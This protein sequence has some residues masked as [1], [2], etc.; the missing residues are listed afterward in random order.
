MPDTHEKCSGH[1]GPQENQAH[2]DCQAT[3]GADI[4]DCCQLFKYLKDGGIW[5]QNASN[6]F[7]GPLLALLPRFQPLFVAYLAEL[8]ALSTWP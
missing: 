1:P 2:D 3:K 8:T 4:A 5:V 7:E 6:A